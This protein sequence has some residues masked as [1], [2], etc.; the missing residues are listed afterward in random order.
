MNALIGWRVVE[1]DA[2]E[3]TEKGCIVRRE[4][5]ERAGHC[6]HVREGVGGRHW[7]I[8]KG[9]WEDQGEEGE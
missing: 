2:V 7:V 1:M 9:M 8:V 5:F 6:A 4:M 3:A